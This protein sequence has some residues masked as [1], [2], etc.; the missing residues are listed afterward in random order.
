MLGTSHQE[1]DMRALAVA[2]AAF[3]LTACGFSTTSASVEQ[4]FTVHG[5]PRVFV[6]TF[7]GEIRAKP[8]SA[9]EVRFSSLRRGDGLT[10]KQAERNLENIEVIARQEG[11]DIF[12]EA[13]SLDRSDDGSVD[14]D[15]TFPEGATLELRTTNAPIIVD[16]A[17]A[18]VARS[19]N[20]KIS[21]VNLTGNADLQTSNDRIELSAKNPIRVQA[22][23]SNGRLKYAGPLAEGLNTFRTSNS[24]VVIALPSETE[25]NLNARTTNS[26]IAVDFPIRQE[27]GTSSGYVRGSVGLDPRVEVEVETSNGRIT[28]KRQ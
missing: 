20:G 10:E 9:G 16:G 3:T 2:L 17:G 21:A 6:T 8:G 19:T 25:F 11:D 24:E 13:R 28:V 5:A 7:N 14:I 4:S 18:L 26:G 12:I 23:T 1:N 15:L 27:T 22:F